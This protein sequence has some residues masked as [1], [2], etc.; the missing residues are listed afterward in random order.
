[1]DR[2]TLDFL[3]DLE[4][5][6][7]KLSSNDA[8]VPSGE[9]EC[10]ICKRVMRVEMESGIHVDVCNDH[11][12]WLDRGELPSILSSIRS[13]QRINRAQ[14]IRKAKRDGKLSGAMF[15]VWSLMFD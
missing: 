9:R 14:A 3:S 1:M 8:I 2:D 11:G 10:P 5:E 4:R 6:Q 7:E 15:G 12:I 13:G